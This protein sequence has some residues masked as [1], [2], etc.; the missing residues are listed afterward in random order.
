MINYPLCWNMQENVIK[1]PLGCVEKHDG[2]P[3]RMPVENVMQ[4]PVGF[5]FMQENFSSYLKMLPWLK[6]KAAHH[7]CPL[8]YSCTGENEPMFKHYEVPSRLPL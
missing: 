3:S 6:K 1:C 8:V 2:L 5:P 7:T 4:C